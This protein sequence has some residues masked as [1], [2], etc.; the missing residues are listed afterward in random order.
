M[1]ITNFLENIINDG[2]ANLPVDLHDDFLRALHHSLSVPPKTYTPASFEIFGFT[3]REFYDLRVLLLRP[4]AYRFTQ[5]L[6][7]N[8]SKILFDKRTT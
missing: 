7:V 1:D 6:D 4:L 8:I 5:L 3:Q 2:R